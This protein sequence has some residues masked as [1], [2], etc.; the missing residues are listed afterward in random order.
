MSNQT[1]L[2]HYTIKKIVFSPLRVH[3]HAKL[4]SVVHI[5]IITFIIALITT[6]VST[7]FF[8]INIQQMD[9]YPIL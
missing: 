2:D 9:P 6:D 8:S 7:R 5:S 3:S 1:C 4:Q